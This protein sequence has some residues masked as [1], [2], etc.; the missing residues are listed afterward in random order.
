MR[1]YLTDYTAKAKVFTWVPSQRTLQ[2]PCPELVFGIGTQT[3]AKSEISKKQKN[4]QKLFIHRV[5]TSCLKLSF[6]PQSPFLNALV[7][8]RLYIGSHGRVTPN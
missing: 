5:G 2:H 6:L 8:T 1:K 4:P 7:S 3:D